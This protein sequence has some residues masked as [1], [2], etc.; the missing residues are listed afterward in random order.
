MAGGGGDDS[1]VV[2]VGVVRSKGEEQIPFGIT[3]RKANAR[4]TAT[5]MFWPAALKEPT[6]DDDEAVVEDGAP[7][8]GLL[9]AW[10]CSKKFGGLSTS[11]EMTEC[12]WVE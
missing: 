12:G 6:L 9:D 8:G 11:V 1:G 2:P 5:A 7:G 10:A 3:E 4:A